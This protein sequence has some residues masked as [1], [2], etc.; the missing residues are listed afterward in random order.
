MPDFLKNVDLPSHPF[1][2]CAV[3]DPVFFED[4]DCYL[5]ACYC[6]RAHSHFAECALAERSTYKHKQKRK[7]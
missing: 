1:N 2:I 3:L 5:L 6:V 7:S 4:F